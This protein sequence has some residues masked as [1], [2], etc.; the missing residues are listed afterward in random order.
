[1][2]EWNEENKSFSIKCRCFRF[3]KCEPLRS[4]LQSGHLSNGALSNFNSLLFHLKENSDEKNLTFVAVVN[5]TK[6]PSDRQMSIVHTTC[7]LPECRRTGARFESSEKK[8][9]N[10][11][12]QS[13]CVSLATNK[14]RDENF[15]DCAGVQILHINFLKEEFF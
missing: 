7:R 1:M 13:V 8:S 11:K 5:P 4:H 15:I 2:F 6:S 12:I 14:S 9:E 3:R 10:N